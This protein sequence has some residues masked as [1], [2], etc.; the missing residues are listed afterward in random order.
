M[1]EW[2]PIAT[3]PE[4][5]YEQI[6]GWGYDWRDGVK[7]RAVVLSFWVPATRR[8]SGNPTH[9]LPVQPPEDETNVS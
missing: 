6:I 4:E 1:S 9:W 7:V 8:F 2:Q 3:A 5:P